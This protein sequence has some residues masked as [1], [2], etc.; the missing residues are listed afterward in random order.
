MNADKVF[1][2]GCD[3]RFKGLPSELCP[4]RGTGFELIWL[5]GWNDMH[6]RWGNYVRSFVNGQ[7]I[8]RWPIMKLRPISKSIDEIADIFENLYDERLSLTQIA[9]MIK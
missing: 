9:H 3:A 8:L 2:E 4:Y 1:G 7:T 5:H 6:K